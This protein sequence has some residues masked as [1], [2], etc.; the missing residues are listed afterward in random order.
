MSW[1][2]SAQIGSWRRLGGFHKLPAI[3]D[4]MWFHPAVVDGD[5]GFRGRH[6]VG[7][8]VD[9]EVV[10]PAGPHT[11][12]DHT[13]QSDDLLAKHLYGGGVLGRHGRWRFRLGW[14]EGVEQF[15]LELSAEL[16]ASPHESLIAGLQ[17]APVV[18]E[19]GE[20]VVADRVSVGDFVSVFVK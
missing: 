9:R 4:M 1:L 17:G 18:H 15:V 14:L 19:E 13:F 2:R 16:K 20:F 8:R 6:R 12:Q 7:G 5:R 11:G 3:C 10:R